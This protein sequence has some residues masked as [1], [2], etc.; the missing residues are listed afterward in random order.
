MQKWITFLMTFLVGSASY[1]NAIGDVNLFAGYR[2]DDITIKHRYPAHNPDFKSHTKFKNID[3]FQV[4]IN[5]RSTI[6]CNF[7]ARAEASWGWILDG[8][9][10]QS[11][12]LFHNAAPI[13]SRSGSSSQASV[14]LWQPKSHESTLDDKYV[15]DANIA[16]GY[17]FYFCDCS[18]IVAPV[19]GYA[20]DAQNF[21][22]HGRS[23]EI[24]RSACSGDRIE[25]N[26]DC[27]KHTYFNRWYGPFV[28][29]DFAYRPTNE[30]FS[31]YA[32]FEYHWGTFKAK[33]SHD[34]G[35]FERR[36]H[37]ADMDGWVVDL[38]ADYELNN[39]WTVGLYLKFTDFSAS[40][41]KRWDNSYDSYYGGHEKAKNS[42]SWNSYAVNVEIGRQ[43]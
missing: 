40:K 20:V 19:I 22:H 2:H 41:H 25:S 24:K 5:A 6:G 16:I 9:F 34:T 12:S 26:S 21:S 39:C 27:C 32:A 38:G 35:D 1:V 7:Y 3:I 14:D 4:G 29:V 23:F 17:P 31:L 15:Y 10:K 36:E 13:W 11:A 37:H 42:G 8:D 18:A 43:F 28:G 33:R 30:C